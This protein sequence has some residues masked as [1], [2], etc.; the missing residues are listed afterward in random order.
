M[1]ALNTSTK[2]TCINKDVFNY[3]NDKDANPIHYSVGLIQGSFCYDDKKEDCMK[4][5]FYSADTTI[6]SYIYN[7]SFYPFNNV[8]KVLNSGGNTGFMSD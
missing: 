1:E 6:S 4:N 5:G 7:S 2:V 3:N 8:I